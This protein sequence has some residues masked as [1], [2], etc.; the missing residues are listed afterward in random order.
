MVAQSLERLEMRIHIN[1][2]NK[3]KGNNNYPMYC[4]EILMIGYKGTLY[5]ES[6]SYLSHT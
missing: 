6:M 2:V 1:H 4:N 5:M 3:E